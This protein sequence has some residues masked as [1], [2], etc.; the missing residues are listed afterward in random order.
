MRSTRPQVTYRTALVLGAVLLWLP[1]AGHAQ[2]NTHTL[3][4]G[5][6]KTIGQAI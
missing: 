1:S 4:C 5:P 6:D 3:T 2:S